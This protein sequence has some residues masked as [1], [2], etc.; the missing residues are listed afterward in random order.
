MD[1]KPKYSY[2]K[3]TTYQQCPY[4]YKLVYIDKVSTVP[5]KYLNFGITVAEVIEEIY[6]NFHLYQN[7]TDELLR[8]VLDKCWINKQVYNKFILSG[9]PSYS[10]LG[11]NSEIEELQYYNNLMSYMKT[12]IQKNPIAHV[13]GIEEK[14]TL[15]FDE[16]DITGRIDWIEFD[17][18]VR[19]LNIIDNKSGKNLISNIKE[20]IQLNLYKLAIE[21][22]YPTIAIN[23]IGFYYLALNKKVMLS[24]ILLETHKVIDIIYKEHIKISQQLFPKIKTAL[25]RFCEV[26]HACE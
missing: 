13:F 17:T 10:F 11:Y 25:C 3:I 9:Q 16:F 14:F 22:T 26:Q 12:Y 2:S 18:N 4:R 7:I 5:S 6:V 8:S 21:K 23:Q 1:L 20:D 24:S 19:M 15:S